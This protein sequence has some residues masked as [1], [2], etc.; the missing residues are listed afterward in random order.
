MHKKQKKQKKKQTT[1]EPM[2]VNEL[3]RATLYAIIENDG[4]WVQAWVED[5]NEDA[6][7]YGVGCAVERSNGNIS[8][9]RAREKI[10]SSIE[11]RRQ[12]GNLPEP[13]E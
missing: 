11:T 8:S 10:Q 3:H 6:L 12:A 2:W 5:N 4:G 13:N 1:S 9:E 7:S